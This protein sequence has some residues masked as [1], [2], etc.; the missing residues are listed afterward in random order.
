MREADE[1]YFKQRAVEERLAAER[2]T[3]PSA[4]RAHLGLS[5]IYEDAAN[6]LRTSVGAVSFPERRAA[7]PHGVSR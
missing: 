4:Q 1:T 2:A 3:H 6:E 7:T 5:N